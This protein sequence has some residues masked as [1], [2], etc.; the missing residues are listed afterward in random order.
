MEVYLGSKWTVIPP[1]SISDILF[2]EKIFLEW[3]FEV[4]LRMSIFVNTF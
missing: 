3:G 1:K 2:L 4:G